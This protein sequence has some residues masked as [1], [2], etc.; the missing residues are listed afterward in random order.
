MSNSL[1]ITT[2][3]LSTYK[4][5]GTA[6]IRTPFGTFYIDRRIDSKRDGTDGYVYD[7]YPTKGKR[8]TDVKLVRQIQAIATEQYD[9][10]VQRTRQQDLSE[11][12]RLRA[13]YPNE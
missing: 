6:E 9:T 5:G 1:R 4:D 10:A 12:R 3:V 8:V 13:K 7:A 2:P 11:L